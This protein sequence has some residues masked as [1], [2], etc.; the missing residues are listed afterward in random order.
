MCRW[1]GGGGGSAPHL[2]IHSFRVCS[3]P[4][5]GENLNGPNVLYHHGDP[6]ESPEH[7]GHVYSLWEVSTGQ[8]TLSDVNFNKGTTVRSSKEP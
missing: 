6:G 4:G 8:Q 2:P 3:E 7:Q 5:R 1:I